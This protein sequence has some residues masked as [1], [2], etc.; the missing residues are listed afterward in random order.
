MFYCTCKKRPISEIKRDNFQW[1]ANTHASEYSQQPTNMCH[2]ENIILMEKVCTTQGWRISIPDQ[3]WDHMILW[4]DE[5]DMGVSLNGGTPISHPKMIIFG[6]KTHGC[7]ETHHFSKT[8]IWAIW[9][10]TPS[11]A[12]RT[13]AIEV[14]DLHPHLQIRNR[15]LWQLPA[16]KEVWCLTCLDVPG[17]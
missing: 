8:P 6:R 9:P 16:V 10:T 1:K 5:D 3:F 7:W 2:S 12:W 13:F 15:L 17:S 4:E 11:C 14:E